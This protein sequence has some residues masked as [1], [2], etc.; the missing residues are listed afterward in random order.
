MF[1]ENELRT[2]LFCSKLHSYGA[3]HIKEDLAFVLVK[4][5]LKTFLTLYSLSQLQEKNI[6]V[7]KLIKQSISAALDCL[8][9]DKQIAS[10]KLFYRNYIS[11]W[12]SY[13]VKDEKL[14][15]KAFFSAYY[16]TKYN[17]RSLFVLLEFLA[18]AFD[19]KKKTLYAYSFNESLDSY[20]SNYDVVNILKYSFLK[21]NF[22]KYK[23]IVLITC[24]CSSNIIS[25]N[26][27]YPNRSNYKKFLS[28]CLDSPKHITVLNH[29]NSKYKE[30]TIARIPACFNKGCP[31]RKVCLN[32]PW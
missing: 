13:F 1:K 25:N 2:Y 16:S 20:L 18:L 26:T 10:Q 24:S 6:T 23:N 22:P 8:P 21:E 29:L 7:S 31:K 3:S 27:N 32:D 17:Y 14:K 12:F 30:R 9:P 15:D 5:A 28:T 4:E 19:K 11:H